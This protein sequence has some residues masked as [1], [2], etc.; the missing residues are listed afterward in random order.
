MMAAQPAFAHADIVIQTNNSLVSALKY[1]VLQ[2]ID[3]LARL[4]LTDAT[5]EHGYYVSDHAAEKTTKTCFSSTRHCNSPPAAAQVICTTT[6]KSFSSGK[7]Q[8][9]QWF[10]TAAS[11]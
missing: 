1:A 10:V 8:D 3:G 7:T 11:A 2:E 9:Q 4:Q 5:H 6:C